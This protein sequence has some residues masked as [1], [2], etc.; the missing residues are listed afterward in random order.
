MGA[1]QVPSNCQRCG[2]PLESG[3][4]LEIRDGN[5]R[6]VSQWIAG[7]PERGFMFGLKTRNRK[8]FPITT[9]R[10]ARCGFHESFAL[11]AATGGKAP[12]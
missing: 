3:Y 8:S 2:G 6:S 11:P 4:V 1:D 12:G 5:V 10:C 7:A 9:F